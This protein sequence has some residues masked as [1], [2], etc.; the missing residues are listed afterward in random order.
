MQNASKGDDSENMVVPGY[1]TSTV[2]CNALVALLGDQKV[3]LPGTA[4]FNASVESYFSQQQQAVQPAC[5]VAPQTTQD[6]SAAIKTLTSQPG[7]KSKFSIRSGGHASWAG[8][9]NIAGGIVIDIR[10]LNL[11]KVNQDNSTVSV[12]AGASWDQVYEQL[13]PI[14]LSVNGGRAA[15]VVT[16]FEIVLADGSTVETNAISDPELFQALKGGNN[17]FGVVT[18]I[19]FTTFQQGLIWTGNVYQN[20]SIVDDVITEVVKITAPDAYDEYASMIVTFGFSQ[21]QGLSVISSVLDYS[22]DVESP[23]IY[24][25][26]LALPNLMNTSSVV[27][28]TTAAKVTRAFSPEHPRSINR[29][30]TLKLTEDV[31]KAVYTQ[32]QASL[33]GLQNVT[34]L[35]WALALEP[36]PPQIYARHAADNSLGLTGKNGTLVVCL[37]TV[38]WTEASDDGVV[39]AAAKSLIGGIADAA[40]KLNGLDHYIY[41][42]YA[43]KDQDVIPSYGTASVSKLQAVRDRVDPQGV[44][45]NQVPGGYKIPPE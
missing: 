13:D 1:L 38:S 3:A 44:F 22:K 24:K 29:V 12:G 17:N 42:N 14:G 39:N 34:G 33:P 8:A 9:S 2:V 43:D 30:L 7:G 31:L 35:L 20:L 23:P 26:F 21:A 28:M 4:A 15:E 40:Q 36:L 25:D 6:V 16:N 11:V 10:A 41:L 19:D 18:R 32:W 5:V 37:L 27:N 45:T